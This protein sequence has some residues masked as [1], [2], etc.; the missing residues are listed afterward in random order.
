MKKIINLVLAII[1]LATFQF[2]LI[3]VNSRAEDLASA[4]VSVDK[5][6][7]EKG[8][9]ITVTVTVKSGIVIGYLGYKL[10]YDAS[11][12]TFIPEGDQENDATG[13]IYE[14]VDTTKGTDTVKNT[15]KFVTKD[16]GTV[17]YTLSDLKNI[18]L[19]SFGDNN[20]QDDIPTSITNTSV[21]IIEKAKSG[22]CSLKSL[23]PSAGTLTPNFSADVLSYTINV[24]VGTK[25]CLLYCYVQDKTAKMVLSG[26]EYLKVGENVRTCTITAENGDSKVYT[27]KI[28]R[29][30]D[31]VVTPT[32]APTETPDA[33]INPD[34]TPD[35][36]DEP[37][38]GDVTI[39]ETTYTIYNITN[40]LNIILNGAKVKSSQNFLFGQTIVNGIK[41]YSG[42]TNTQYVVLASKNGG[43]KQI[44]I[45]DTEDNSIQRYLGSNEK[46]QYAFDIAENPYEPEPTGDISTMAPT[47]TP[48]ITETPS[49]TTTADND[50]ASG[51]PVEKN[52]FLGIVGIA[53]IIII[54]LVLL[55]LIF[56]KK[57]D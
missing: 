25:E 12:V 4:I 47:A 21:K 53:G 9:T 46:L 56:M 6:E 31:P 36:P 18:A 15:Y 11:L 43:E 32:I 35:I 30:E 57:K 52:K 34:A 28:I 39:N 41:A 55:S 8:G 24:P 7:V 45:F 51:I 20:D 27:I 26:S 17:G 48:D 14:R 5:T 33:T 1:L 38:I 22:N 44:Y 54:A 40:E 49:A 23:Q 10:N 13:I 2:S 42:T 50:S 29:P 3:P 37:A 16:V 19:E